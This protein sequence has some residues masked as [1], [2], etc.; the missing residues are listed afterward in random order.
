MACYAVKNYVYIGPLKEIRVFSP[1]RLIAIFMLAI[2]M[3]TVENAHTKHASLIIAKLMPTKRLGFPLLSYY[4]I[5]TVQYWGCCCVKFYGWCWVWS[6]FGKSSQLTINVCI[7]TC[8]N[9]HHNMQCMHVHTT[10]SAYV[11]QKHVHV[12]KENDN[13]GSFLCS[14]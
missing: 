12:G 8:T 4:R 11:V 1:N 6:S 9:I 14:S 3:T 2:C 10:N 5:L 7:E 13:Q